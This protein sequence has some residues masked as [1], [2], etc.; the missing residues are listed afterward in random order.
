MH[1]LMSSRFYGIVIS[2]W[3]F[4]P[5]VATMNTKS[6]T[7]T[8]HEQTAPPVELVCVCSLFSAT[9]LLCSSRRWASML[10]GSVTTA[11]QSRGRL[12]NKRYQHIEAHN[13]TAGAF[14]TV[15]LAGRALS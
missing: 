4:F 12:Q 2:H 10:V 8:R 9:A 1:M 11:Q 6:L 13:G 7:A 3:Y 15:V 5:T 14:W